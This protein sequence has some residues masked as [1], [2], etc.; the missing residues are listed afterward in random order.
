VTAEREH[1]AV[2]DPRR[3]RQTKAIRAPSGEIAICCGTSAM[4]WPVE[5]VAVGGAK[6]ARTF[7][8]CASLTISLP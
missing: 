2:V 5:S 4:T 6:W 7:P 8:L 3:I 1:A